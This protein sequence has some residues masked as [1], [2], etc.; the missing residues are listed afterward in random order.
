MTLS[1]LLLSLCPAWGEWSEHPPLRVRWR[2]DPGHGRLAEWSSGR[3]RQGEDV[4]MDR[5]YAV[6]EPQCFLWFPCYIFSIWFIWTRTVLPYCC[7]YPHFNTQ[8]CWDLIDNSWTAWHNKMS[9][10]ADGK[11]FLDYSYLVWGT[12]NY[13]RESVILSC[14]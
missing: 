1:F 5:V 13:S 2:R 10:D 9:L 11:L 3:Q 6:L 12:V 4:L 8:T 7:S 14:A